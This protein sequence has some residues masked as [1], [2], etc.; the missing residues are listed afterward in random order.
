MYYNTNRVIPQESLAITLSLKCSYEEGKQP[1]S[2]KLTVKPSKYL[3]DFC[4]VCCGCYLPALS[5][6]CFS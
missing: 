1:W 5:S 2:Q 6:K 4:S 3:Q